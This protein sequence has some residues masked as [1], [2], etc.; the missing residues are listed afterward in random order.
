MLYVYEVCRL[1]CLCL[2]TACGAAFF[3][4]E[5]CLLVLSSLGHFYF[6][7]LALESPLPSPAFELV[8]IHGWAHHTKCARI[9]SLHCA[10]YASVQ[11]FPRHAEPHVHD[12]PTTIQLISHFVDHPIFSIFLKNLFNEIRITDCILNKIIQHYHSMYFQYCRLQLSNVLYMSLIIKS[13]IWIAC[14]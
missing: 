12:V 4:T 9:S 14:I 2:V 11:A 5:P 1:P 8:C 10:I 7:L 13:F 3:R 6:S